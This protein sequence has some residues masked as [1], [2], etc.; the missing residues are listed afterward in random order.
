MR[1]FSPAPAPL[2]D[3]VLRTVAT[4]LIAVCAGSRR[5]AAVV[6]HATS[7]AD[8]RCATARAVRELEHV[9]ALAVGRG[10]VG[11]TAARS[12]A[13]MAYDVASQHPER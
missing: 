7:V 2:F 6:E 12:V 8:E 3:D 13:G 9:L 4:S 11:E 1:L 5:N 10:L